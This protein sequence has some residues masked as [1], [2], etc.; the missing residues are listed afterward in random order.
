MSQKLDTSHQELNMLMI[1]QQKLTDEVEQG[2]KHLLDEV[3][4]EM[5]S[6]L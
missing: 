3:V 6:V 4:Q 2:I 5:A 1:K